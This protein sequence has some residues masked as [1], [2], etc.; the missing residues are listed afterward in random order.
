MVELGCAITAAKAGV[1]KRLCGQL[2][3]EMQGKRRA[4]S[5]PV[6][7]DKKL[8]RRDLAE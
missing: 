3:R 8:S 6:R 1:L 7:L 2:R 4:A 5:R